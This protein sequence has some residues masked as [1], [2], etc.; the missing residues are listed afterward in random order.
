M[1]FQIQLGCLLIARSGPAPRASRRGRGVCGDVSSGGPPFSC[2]IRLLPLAVCS[3]SVRCL[4]RPLPCPLAEVSARCRPTPRRPLP[5]LLCSTS[6]RPVWPAHKRPSPA[7]AALAV[8]SC[9][10]RV[11]LRR[12]HRRS[13]PGRERANRRPRADHHNRDHRANR[14][15]PPKYTHSTFRPDAAKYRHGTFPKP[16]V[17]TW[18][19]S[20]AQKH[21]KY[22]HTTFRPSRSTHQS[23]HMAR[24]A[25]ISKYTHGTFFQAGKVH[26]WNKKRSVHTWNARPMTKRIGPPERHARPWREPHPAPPAS[27]ATT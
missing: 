16:K 15:P 9:M 24:P 5:L 19:V 22:T 1:F 10:G 3:L 17:H 4:V 26:T 7:S 20:E 25:E 23:T 11:A 13:G 14:N 21:P 8:A 18:H 12:A 27:S 6:D 2:C